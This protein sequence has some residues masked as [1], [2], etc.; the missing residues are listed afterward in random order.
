MIKSVRLKNFKILQ[1]TTLPLSPFTL[2]VGPNGSGKSTALT[3]LQKLIGLEGLRF[4]DL[5]AA[6][7][8][9]NDWEPVSITIQWGKPFEGNETNVFWHP[10]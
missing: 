6:G 8:G 7:L 3:A 1:D 9:V 2:I 10:D 4:G 5:V